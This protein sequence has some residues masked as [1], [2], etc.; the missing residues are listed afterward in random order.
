LKFNISVIS[1]LKKNKS[2]FY[3]KEEKWT[4]YFKKEFK[5]IKFK[6]YKVTGSVIKL[7]EHSFHVLIKDLFIWVVGINIMTCVCINNII[8]GGLIIQ[9]VLQ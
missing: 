5:L 7:F 9:S 8:N 3:L 2:I 1:E 4:F 6:G